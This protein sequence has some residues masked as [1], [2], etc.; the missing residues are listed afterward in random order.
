M[1]LVNKTE[2]ERRLKFTKLTLKFT[3]QVVNELHEMRNCLGEPEFDSGGP[4]PLGT[5][6]LTQRE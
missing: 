2:P 4:L 3:N 5:G 1:L 6:Q